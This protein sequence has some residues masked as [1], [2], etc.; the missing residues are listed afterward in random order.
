M[1]QKRKKALIIDDNKANRFVLEVVLKR[2]GFQTTTQ[3]DG[4]A[5]VDTLKESFY[6]LVLLDISMPVLMGDE[7][8]AQI[9]K[10]ISKDKLGVI[11][12]YTAHALPADKEQFMAVGFDDLLIK[13]INLAALREKLQK[14]NL[15]A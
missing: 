4:L 2:L 9:K 15:I 12:A 10:A 7:L 3:K 1:S 6:D 8:C 11:F 14:F 5:V 13:P